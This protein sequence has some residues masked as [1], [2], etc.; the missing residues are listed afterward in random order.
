MM[1]I[2]LAGYKGSGK[3]TAAHQLELMGFGRIAFASVLKD[4]LK[5]F[6]LTDRQLYGDQKETPDDNVLCGKTPRWAMQSLGTEWGRDCIGHDVWIRAW[7]AKVQTIRHRTIGVVVDDVR[8]QSEFDFL[9]EHGGHV[10]QVH[11]DGC[12]AGDHRSEDIP[13]KAHVHVENN[14]A[15][16][17][18]SRTMSLLVDEFRS[19]L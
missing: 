2:G 7:W 12:V 15:V 11:R 16:D 13:F 3:T 14:G 5:T 6:G 19:K 9:C 4:M 17:A 18:L 1:L 8:F 10:I